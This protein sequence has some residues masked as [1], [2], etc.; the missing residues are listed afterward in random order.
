MLRVMVIGSQNIPI[1]KQLWKEAEYTVGEIENK[2]S[3]HDYD[4][5][6]SYQILP[7][8]SYRDTL[9]AL[10]HWRGLLKD[11]GELCIFVQSLEWAAEQIL[12]EKASALL[13]VHL[14]GT[15]TN[16]NEFHISGFT[17]L[18]LRNMVAEAGFAVT[19]ANTGEYEIEVNGEKYVAEQ[20]M[21]YARKKKDDTRLPKPA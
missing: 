13:R 20:H 1:A 16:K 6:F 19:Q 15:Q 7:K 9:S 14:F 3:R 11:D 2:K 5:V 18:D 4:V 17:M 21:L 10:R 8:I 12:S